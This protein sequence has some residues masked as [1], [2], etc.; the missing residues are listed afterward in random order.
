MV[1][2]GDPQQDEDADVVEI[3]FTPFET[4]N[5][6]LIVKAKINE[7]KITVTNY[8]KI[9]EYIAIMAMAQIS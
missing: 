7:C 8:S 9:F 1:C 6:I 3:I 4:V 5:D 2:I